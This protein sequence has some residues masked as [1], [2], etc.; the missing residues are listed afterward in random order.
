MTAQIVRDK[1]ALN[2][3]GHRYDADAVMIY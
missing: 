3:I 1:V 2:T